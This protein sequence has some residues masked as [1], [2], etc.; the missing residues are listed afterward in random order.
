MGGL[1]LIAF[2]SLA[3]AQKNDEPRP[4]RES[5]MTGA[6]EPAQTRAEREGEDFEDTGAARSITPA[7][8]VHGTKSTDGRENQQELGFYI[9]LRI[10]GGTNT[11]INA[12]RDNASRF[13]LFGSRDFAVGWSFY[14]R[15]ELGINLTE[16]VNLLMNPKA[17]APE[18]AN[19]LFLRL[20]YLG[21]DGPLGRLA[22][23]KQWSGYYAVAVFTDRFPFS[24]GIAS[25]AL[26]AGTDGGASGTGRAT[27]SLEYTF[28]NGGLTLRAQTQSGGRKIPGA[29]EAVYDRSGGGSVL[30]KWEWGVAL[31]AAFNYSGVGEITDEVRLL[32]IDGPAQAW[33][34]GF[35]IQR[36]PVYVGATYVEHR[37]HETDDQGTYFD[38]RGGELLLRFA[39]RDRF[40]FSGG[41]NYLEPFGR[42]ADIQY[43]IKLG[44][45][46]LEYSFG[47][48][49]FQ[50]V[51]YGEVIVD[52]SRRRD[53]TSY[54]N[55]YVV[56]FRRS[57]DF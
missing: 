54:P 37:N 21:I 24:G 25:A 7:D 44:I 49:S 51:L 47:E 38:G 8:S 48:P 5:A 36:S 11:E 9:S 10:V 22:L 53:G 12:V 15:T 2:F 33:I 55:A 13:G 30:Y 42:S 20:G 1:F 50:N 29:V 32:G 19:N 31:G 16:E 45:F 3:A 56:G 35:K 26:N 4:S 17:N 27:G 34:A 46:S 18:G 57:F 14:A 28:E 52:S 40:R 23:G 41:L 39:W 43:E 6:D